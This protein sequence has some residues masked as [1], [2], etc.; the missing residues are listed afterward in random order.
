MSTPAQSAAPPPATESTSL[1]ATL[2]P[3]RSLSPNPFL[4]MAFLL[5]ISLIGFGGYRASEYQGM[6]IL[7]TDAG[8]R[9]DL[10]AAAVDGIVNRYAHIPATIQLNEEVLGVMQRTRHPGSILAANRFL[11]RLNEHIGSIAIFVVNERGIVIASSNWG[12]PDN[13]FVGED[14]SFRS[15]FLDG[16]AGRSGHHFAIGITRG[17]PGYFV[18]HPIRSGNRVVGVAVIKISLGQL[19][20]AWDLLGAPALIADGNGVVIL[21]SVP[22][23]RYT[24]LTPLPLD[25]RVDIKLS[26]L[27][28]DGPI[29][30]FPVSVNPDPGPEGQ[31]VHMNLRSSSPGVPAVRGRPDVAG[32]Y[33]VHGRGLQDVG[34]RLLIFSDLR[35]VR[36]QAFGHGA[37]AA[38]ATGFVLLLLLVVAQRRRI[39]RQKLEAKELLEQANAQ[40]ESKVARRTRALTDTNA[41]LRKEVAERQQAEQTLRAAQDELVQAAKLAVLGQLAA[42]ITHELAQPL[43]AMRTLSGNAV[44][45]MK[46]GNLATVEQNLGIIARLADQMGRIITPLKTFARKSPAI[47]APADLAHAVGAALFLLDQ[48]LAKAGISV[49]NRLE[50]GQH[51][52]WCDQN[53]LEQVLINL[54]RNAGDAMAESPLKTLQIDAVQLPD[55]SLELAI[56]DSGCGLPADGALFEPFFTTKPA[57]EGLGLGLAISRDIVREFGGDL[58]AEN[59]PEGGARFIL[60]LPAAPKESP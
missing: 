49:D 39:V 36:A 53:R 28:N 33:L 41:R 24:A 13:S 17:E 15:Y 10:F 58:R 60:N 21:T 12:D 51:I 8:H 47:P 35:P 42:G 32:S 19:D 11:Q 3:S 50:A 9:L 4:V 54:I 31:I 37:L 22:E 14:L 34:W 56:A 29:G 59:R 1:A 38:V 43:G 57:G 30:D 52:A 46:R 27:Y 5:L 55:G 45:F 2:P 40:L 44:E 16:L 25:T 26:R 18:S 20:K 7:R 23:W 6:Q 48:R